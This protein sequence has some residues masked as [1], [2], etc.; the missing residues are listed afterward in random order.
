[1]SI[2]WLELN[3]LGLPAEPYH[4][5]PV[6]E[7]HVSKRSCPRHPSGL[8]VEEDVG[9]ARAFTALHRNTIAEVE[10]LVPSRQ[11]TFSHI[12]HN[13][14]DIG[15]RSGGILTTLRSTVAIV[16]GNDQRIKTPWNGI[17]ETGTP[18]K[19]S[20]SKE[21]RP[22]TYQASTCMTELCH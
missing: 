8:F 17:G 13:P 12:D 5:W 15:V 21:C 16:I 19:L 6:S 2:P 11:T 18:N 20:L 9:G 7:P 1:M 3:H 4:N 14:D 22:R 10:H